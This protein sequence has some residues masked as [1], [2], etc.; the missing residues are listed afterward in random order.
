[1]REFLEQV[2]IPEEAVAV[3]LGAVVSH[4]RLRERRNGAVRPKLPARAE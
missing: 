2:H 1:L 3:G 4:G